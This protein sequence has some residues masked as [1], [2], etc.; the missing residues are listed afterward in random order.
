[1]WR[2]IL[3]FEDTAADADENADF[4]VGLRGG[5][6][7]IECHGRWTLYG[8]RSME[9]VRAC[10]CFVEVEAVLQFPQSAVRELYE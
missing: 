6:G 9:G 7:E 10:K 8:S 2:Q 5:E 1:L 4:G 3:G